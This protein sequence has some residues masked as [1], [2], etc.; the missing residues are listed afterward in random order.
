VI[1]A[2]E[3]TRATKSRISFL[4]RVNPHLGVERRNVFRAPSSIRFSI[5][6]GFKP[7]NLMRPPH[8][9]AVDEASRRASRSFHFAA[10]TINA[11]RA[12]IFLATLPIIGSHRLS[13]SLLVSVDA[14]S[15]IHS[16]SVHW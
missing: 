14:V 3:E 11:T 1:V 12:K 9:H 13:W 5:P 16:S 15:I 2:V 8:A 4:P 6:T 10:K 7:V